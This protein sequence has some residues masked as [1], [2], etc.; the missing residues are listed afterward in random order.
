MVQ[1]RKLRGSD[2][3]KRLFFKTKTLIALEEAFIEPSNNDFRDFTFI[4]ERHGE[5]LLGQKPP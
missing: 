2:F 1:A 4:L 5:N 3:P